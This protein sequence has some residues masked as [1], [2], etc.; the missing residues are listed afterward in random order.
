MNLPAGMT[1]QLHADRVS[2]RFLPGVDWLGLIVDL[3]RHLATVSSRQVDNRHRQSD[4]QCPRKTEQH[5]AA[6]VGLATGIRQQRRELRPASSTLAGFPRQHLF[7]YLQEPD[8]QVRPQLG[9]QARRFLPRRLSIGA[10]VWKRRLAGKEEVQCAAQAVNVGP[11]VGAVGVLGPARAPC[12]SACPWSSR[13]R[14]ACDR[15]APR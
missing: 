14:A 7:Q 9:E 4:Y 1:C 11:D 12:S 3:F 10:V 15:P 6:V 5:L 8:R 2:D 13:S